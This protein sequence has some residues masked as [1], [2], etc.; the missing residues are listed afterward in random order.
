MLSAPLTPAP[1]AH[2]VDVEVTIL[3]MDRE[4][5]QKREDIK[6]NVV[7]W[8]PAYRE[9]IPALI[10]NEEDVK[11]QCIR[12]ESKNTISYCRGGSILYSLQPRNLNSS[13]EDCDRQRHDTG[14]FIQQPPVPVSPC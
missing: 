14:Y 4:L 9:Q 8:T 12:G 6:R 5:R 7:P 13:F 10:L 11:R 1:P 3:R 2:T